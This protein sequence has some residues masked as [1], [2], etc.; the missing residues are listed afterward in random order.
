[1]L[2]LDENNTSRKT[3]D[4]YKK[5]FEERFIQATMIFY[6]TESEK[7]IA[8][9]SIVEYLKKAETRLKEEET[10]VDMYL[11]ESTMKPVS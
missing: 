5:Y 6:K 4:I 11:D 1:M 10:R 7:F 3:L 2:G 9:N 8:N